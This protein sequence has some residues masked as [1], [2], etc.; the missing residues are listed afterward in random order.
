MYR[1][2]GAAWEVVSKTPFTRILSNA[3][4]GNY[5]MPVAANVAFSVIGR[6]WMH[7]IIVPW[8]LTVDRLAYIIG[9]AANGNVR[10]GIYR[11]GSYGYPDLPD[12][13]PLSVES[14]SVA[15]G[16][17]GTNRVHWIDIVPTVL[18]PSLYFIG[19]QGDN[20]AGTMFIAD[21]SYNW[22]DNI[23]GYVRPGRYYDHAYGPFTNPCPVTTEEAGPIVYM[24]VV[25]T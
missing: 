2:T 3:G 17:L 19:V 25:P 5:G 24:R 10:I 21:Y 23:A 20:V 13:G 18:N 1:D 4:V 16:G 11:Y 8:N 22:I 9:A 15:Q 6:V 12:G 14:A 7:P